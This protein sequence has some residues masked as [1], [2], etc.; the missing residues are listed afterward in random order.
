MIKHRAFLLL[1]LAP[2]LLAVVVVL[3]RST[4]FAYKLNIWSL[5]NTQKPF[6]NG[7][8]MIWLLG[9]REWLR[10]PLLGNGNFAGNFHNSAVT[11]LVG[12]GAVGY[13][14]YLGAIAK[15]L[16]YASR[17]SDDTIVSGLILSY[18]TIWLHQSLEL[19]L[20]AP[21]GNA[22]PFAILGLLLA[23]TKTLEREYELQNIRDRSDLQRG[24]VS[25]QMR[26]GYPAPNRAYPGN[27]LG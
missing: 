5:N 6:F 20:V 12:S 1:L 22:I 17:F 7:R 10:N 13:C 23:R 2:L 11:L 8:D 16:N 24:G 25:P 19:G 3:I 15:I 4:P 26:G 18:L 27:H 9:F 21:Q 14:I